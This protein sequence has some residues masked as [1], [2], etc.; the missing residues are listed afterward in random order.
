[1]T[2]SR[3]ISGTHL[4][5]VLMKAHRALSQHAKHSFAEMDLGFTDFTILEALLH[6]GPQLVNDIGRR[7]HL[8]S[9]AITTAVDRLEERRLITRIVDTQDR[10][11]RLVALTSH[12]RTLIEKAF[13]AH[14]RRMNAAAET[15]TAGQRAQLYTLLKKL[16]L[17]A[18]AMLDV[19]EAAQQ[20]VPVPRPRRSRP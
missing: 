10:R 20:T 11:A 6:K 17:G 2:A 15:L 13:G 5:L 18:A 4:F 8:T 1:L 7:I 12:G 3:E 19:G 14:E 9:G 16:G